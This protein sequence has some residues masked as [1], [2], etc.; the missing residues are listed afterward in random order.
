MKKLFTLLALAAASLSAVATDYTD[1]LVVTVDGSQMSSAQ[2][3]IS[4][5]ANSNGTYT[6]TLKNFKLS[7]MAVGTIVIDD[8]PAVSNGQTSLLK[9]SKDI[10]IKKG[11]G[12]GV[13]LGP[14]LGNVPVNMTGEL[15]GDKFYTKIVISM[16]V[17]GKTQNIDVVFG[18]GHYQL[19]NAGFENF[20]TATLT[21]PADPDDPDA[22]LAQVT[23]DEPD[24]WHS[25]MSASGSEALVWM[26]G[27]NPVTFKSSDVRPGS[28][29]KQSV[30]L[31]SVDIMGPGFIANGTITTG[32][33]NTGSIMASSTDDN[34]A[35]SDITSTDKDAHGDPF[36]STIYSRP[37]AMKVWVKYTQ[38]T[39]NADYPYATATAL[40]NDGTHF[41]EPAPSETVYTNVVGE[42]RNPQIADTKGEWKELTIPFAYDD[43]KANGAIAKSVLVTFSTNAAP[44]QGSHSD[45]PTNPT[46]DILYVD[47]MS[48]VY[49]AG[50]AAVSFTDGDGEVYLL[51]G[52]NADTKEYNATLPFDVTAGNFKAMSD[53]QGAYV[54][55]TVDGGVATIEITSNDLLTT[56][57]YKVNIAKG[58]AGGVT[59]GISGTVAG[60]EQAISAIFTIDGK[61]VNAM[62][63][64][65]LYIVKFA[66]G[67]VKK[68]MNK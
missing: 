7:V 3:T 24:N 60:N 57:T 38:E 34:Y 5:D 54:S 6:L 16:K 26:A 14:T 36:Y 48:F 21:Q 22:E 9:V 47:D 67:S 25:F 44:G 40:L 53:G 43:F 33:M 63:K 15:R 31:K 18:E 29:G 30:M 65:G 11:D 37:D 66:D 51:D 1:Q 2:T 55:T 19:P 27:F 12:A 52:V 35:W 45:D 64:G 50:L 49:N 62:A 41:Q 42:A 4:V 20:H 28:T 17:A 39:P 59:T 56:N 10:K 32:R 68:V 8:V 13:W 61:R 23:S 58:N 46:S